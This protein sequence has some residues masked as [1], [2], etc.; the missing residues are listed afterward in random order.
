MKEISKGMLSNS[1]FQFGQS[2]KSNN[3]KYII[4]NLNSSQK[5]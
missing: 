2:E 3:A 5:S 4:V 1:Q